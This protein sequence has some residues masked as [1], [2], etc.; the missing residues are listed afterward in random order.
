MSAFHARLAARTS[1]VIEGLLLGEQMIASLAIPLTQLILFQI[2][3]LIFRGINR[4]TV[5]DLVA[6]ILTILE[7]ALYLAFF[8]LEEIDCPG[9]NGLPDDVCVPE[10]DSIRT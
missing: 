6:V 7:H 5:K 3:V 10:I 4:E 2:L 1:S 8:A 9:F